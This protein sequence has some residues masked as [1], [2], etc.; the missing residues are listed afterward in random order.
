MTA[1]IGTNALD[2]LVN[3][4]D[5]VAFRGPKPSVLAAPKKDT[6][7]DVLNK[8]RR[9]LSAARLDYVFNTSM[10]THF[11]FTLSCMIGVWCALLIIAVCAV[12]FLLF[13]TTVPACG[14]VLAIA[15]WL[16]CKYV[17]KDIIT[18]AIATTQPMFATEPPSDPRHV[19]TAMLET[20]RELRA[21]RFMAQMRQGDFPINWP[22][23]VYPACDDL[24]AAYDA[25]VKEGA[26]F[27]E[28]KPEDQVTVLCKRVL[29]DHVVKQG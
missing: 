1:L 26:G 4:L 22:F 19:A 27:E 13:Y 12:I 29:Y 20:P 21:R 14:V 17:I 2:G 18:P 23:G 25:L 28:L 10:E 15:T 11:S 6:R 7:S 3:R 16:S 24:P 9:R 5:D 8:A